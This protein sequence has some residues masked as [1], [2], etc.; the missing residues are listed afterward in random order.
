MHYG[1]IAYGILNNSNCM[2]LC[3]IVQYTV[4]KVVRQS[5]RRRVNHGVGRCNTR[6]RVDESYYKRKHITCHEIIIVPFLLPRY[7]NKL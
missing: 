3:R 4:C 7:R 1:V 2:L 6:Y 5:Y